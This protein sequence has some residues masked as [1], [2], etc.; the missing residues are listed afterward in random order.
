MGRSDAWL[1]LKLPADAADGWVVEPEFR[2]PF[3]KP[4]FIPMRNSGAPFRI[5]HHQTQTISATP[6]QQWGAYSRHR[7]KPQLW[8]SFAESNGFVWGPADKLGNRRKTGE[9]TKLGGHDTVLQSVP[10]G[11]A[12]WS[13]KNSWRRDGWE[14][15]HQ[16]CV[17]VEFEGW[18]AESG[19]LLRSEEDK[20]GELTGL[21]LLWNEK[22][23]SG[24]VLRAN[25][26]RSIGESG[27][28]AWGAESET[29][30]PLDVWMNAEDP[31]RGRISVFTHQNV[32][33]GNDHWDCGQSYNE[34]ICGSANRFLD[35]VAS[36]ETPVEDAG[37]DDLLAGLGGDL[38]RAED[39]IVEARR[40]LRELRRRK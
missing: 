16:N 19:D 18:S 17:Q 23:G 1:G 38:D 4:R 35:A 2:V 30:A 31:D 28:I 40:K 29:R 3:H 7:S 12:G 37:R 36:L 32:G 27:G 20:W 8:V 5:V 34:L 25:P 9:R 33:S 6:E 10:L 26:Y 13:L 11:F 24:E 15:N 14:T 21:I 39:A 22:F